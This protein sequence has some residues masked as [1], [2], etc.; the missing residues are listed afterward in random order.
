MGLQRQVWPFLPVDSTS[1]SEE[2][3]CSAGNLSSA[4]KYYVL[5]RKALGAGELWEAGGL[6]ERLWGEQG[7]WGA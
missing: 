4:T 7:E 2:S 6:V 1:F 3:I 5:L